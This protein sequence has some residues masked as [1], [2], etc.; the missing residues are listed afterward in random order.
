MP[1]LIRF[2]G[3]LHGTHRSRE[4]LPCG[5]SYVLRADPWSEICFVGHLT[6][7]EQIAVSIH[8]QQPSKHNKYRSKYQIHCVCVCVCVCECVSV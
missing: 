4:Q 6:I 3:D 2:K 5:R 1:N 8:V 7:R